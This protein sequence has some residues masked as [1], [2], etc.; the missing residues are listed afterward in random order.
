MSLGPYF[1][2]PE[3]SRPHFLAPNGSPLKI[4]YHPKFRFLDLNACTL[5]AGIAVTFCLGGGQKSGVDFDYKMVISPS[6]PHNFFRCAGK[7]K[8]LPSFLKPLPAESRSIFLNVTT[9]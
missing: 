8:D 3:R 2:A 5:I 9:S 4:D 7:E 1:L 6:K